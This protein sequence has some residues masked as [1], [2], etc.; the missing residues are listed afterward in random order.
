MEKVVQVATLL[1]LT[2]LFTV[3]AALAAA[4]AN[5]MQNRLDQNCCAYHRTTDL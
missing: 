2:G 1:A 5:N 3:S 4:P